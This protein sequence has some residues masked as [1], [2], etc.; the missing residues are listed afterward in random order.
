MTPLHWRTNL[1][2]HLTLHPA[3]ILYGNIFDR[4]PGTEQGAATQ[5]LEELLREVGREAGYAELIKSDLAATS[6]PSERRQR[7]DPFAALRPS[8]QGAQLLLFEN[9]QALFAELTHWREQ[10]WLHH[11]SLIRLIQL[12]A[13]RH[14][15][16][17]LFPDETRIPVNFLRHL[18][19]VQR[20]EIPLPDRSERAAWIEQEMMTAFTE[21]G[22]GEDPEEIEEERRRFA[23]LS[24]DLHWS[25]LA[26][27]R[28]QLESE[29]SLGTP[30]SPLTLLRRYKFGDARDRWAEL[31]SEQRSRIRG[32]LAA[33][34]EGRGAIRGQHEAVKKA[35]QV[36]T[37][38]CYNVTEIVNPSYRRPRGVLFFTGPT[39][40][41]KT[42]LAKRLAGLIF[43]AEE[44][45]V[46]FDMSEYS[47]PHSEAR[48]TGAPPGYVGYD[49]GGQLTG[50]L[51][52]NPFS[53]VLFD[54]I[55]KAHPAVLSK[56]LQILDEGRLTD[57]QGQTV[58]FSEALLIFTSNVGSATLP[59]PSASYSDLLAH[60]VEALSQSP[61]FRERP[62]LL[63]RI[64]LS[65][66]IP[67]RHIDD[68]QL[69]LAEI[70]TLIAQTRNH[71]DGQHPPITLR[72]D[73]QQI[74][75]QIAA[76]A[77]WR[78]FG[79]RN[80]KHTFE[81]E[82][83]EPLAVALIDNPNHRPVQLDI[84]AGALSARVV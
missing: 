65:N 23:A 7:P 34:T 16:L 76:K 61:L 84:E 48:L 49:A 57:S 52:R 21:L 81:A 33:L 45:C 55:E 13:E 32:A 12:F 53:V 36:V 25:E 24:D 51:A 46:I 28:S 80:V 63:N 31:V 77:D 74:A 22:A 68:E 1:R 73:D 17:F 47:E 11:A 58:Y 38:A 29:K 8:E 44:A 15:F 66:V 20:F 14:R 82:L 5:T 42:M 26:M 71:L 60:Y 4:F 69:V 62:E 54:E 56:F 2:H 9:T 79:M 30:L 19:A 41:G 70:H 18:P 83:L 10:D 35:I 67:F 6:G 64:G 75:Q 3:L 43:G 72:L 59:D 27:L 39:G 50:A 40:V 78:R 37:R